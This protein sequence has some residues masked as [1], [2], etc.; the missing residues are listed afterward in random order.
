[1]DIID[2]S[3][4]IEE[5]MITFNAP[6]HPVVYIKQ[7]GRITFEGRETREISFGT[8]TGTHIDAPLHFIKGG[9]SVD[10]IPLQKLVGEVTIIDFSHLKE[11]EAVTS[12][13]LSKINITRKMIFKFGW[14]KHWG[15]KK[16]YKDYP[17]F[18]RD[19]ANFL[20]SKKVELIAFDIPSPDDSRIEIG[21][22]EDSPIHK[23]LLSNEIILVEYV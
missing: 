3:Y 16:F 20:V 19:A 21:V 23:I 12:E 17:Y 22:D 14:G 18:T 13:M 5:G 6:W 4:N 1:M 8:H 15:D 9:K 2:L 11:N 10:Y 7:L